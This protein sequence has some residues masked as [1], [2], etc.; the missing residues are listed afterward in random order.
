MKRETKC[1]RGCHMPLSA[2]TGSFGAC[3]Q[4]NCRTGKTM[5]RQITTK[6]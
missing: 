4:C 3:D 1:K 2:F 6:P 5:A